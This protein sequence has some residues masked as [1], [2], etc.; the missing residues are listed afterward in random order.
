M[1]IRWG[2]RKMEVSIR[3]SAPKMPSVMAL[4]RK[5]ALVQ[6]VPYTA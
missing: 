3:P 1:T 4:P 2:M 5:A 6:T